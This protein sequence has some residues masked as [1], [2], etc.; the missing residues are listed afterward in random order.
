MKTH[1]R[2]YEGAEQFRREKRSEFSVKEIY[3][4]ALDKKIGDRVDYIVRKEIE[5]S[6]TQLG[7]I[8]VDGRRK[9]FGKF[10]NSLF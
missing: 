3:C 1:W 9:S 2:N 4:L 5:Q 8:K 6:L 10:G 7:F